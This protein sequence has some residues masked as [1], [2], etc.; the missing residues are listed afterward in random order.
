M[1]LEFSGQSFDKYL[2]IK[3]HENSFSGS[4]VV[5]CG[6]TEGDGRTDMTKLIVAFRSFANAPK[7]DDNMWEK[8][9][10]SKHWIERKKVIE[11]LSEFKYL[12]SIISNY[13]TGRDLD[14]RIQTFYKMNGVI[15]RKFGKYITKEI[16]LRLHNFTSKAALK[17]G[18]E[19]WVLK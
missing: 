7:K 17:Y 1:K 18:S 15:R 12:G 6:R 8:Y 13:S 2:N 9:S 4:L 19:N 11:R 14:H 16:Q 10:R 5:P 3:F